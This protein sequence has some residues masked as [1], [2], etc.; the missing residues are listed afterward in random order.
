[1]YMNVNA[2]SNISHVSDNIQKKNV[3]FGGSIATKAT[4][5][6]GIEKFLSALGSVFQADVDISLPQLKKLF[7]DNNFK[8]N[9]NGHFYKKLSSIE[10]NN[11]DKRFG[12]KSEMVKD[13]F[14][15]VP[16]EIQNQFKDFLSI[17]NNS[18]LAKT[19]FEEMY[20]LFSSMNESMKSYDK[21]IKFFKE[22]PQYAQF[23]QNLAIN[24]VKTSGTFDAIS[25]YKYKGDA[26]IN[27]AL[28]GQSKSTPEINKQINAISSFI[29]TQK[30]KTPAR[31]YRGE[32]IERLSN[33]KLK[34]GKTVNLA[35]MMASARGDQNKIN[36][37]REFVLDN[38]LEA[39]EKGFM[40][41]TMDKSIALD[42]ASPKPS[43]TGR[44]PKMVWILDTKPNTKGAYLDPLNLGGKA[45][46]EKEVL[47]QRDS[48]I[49]IKDIN[50][51]DGLWYVKGEVSNT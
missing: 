10:L 4:N 35:E 30:I 23:I 31:L 51:K 33:V 28:R 16:V 9:K 20:I 44:V 50:F 18:K 14:A 47:L 43:D 37:I 29:D 3:S 45:S 19:N 39:T 5:S 25:K 21:T 46:F 13:F 22:K 8:M 38:S 6:G 2:I 32:G 41:T 26:L 42:F 36:K 12:D 1:M 40:S 34:N 48:N 17:G 49:K 11:I 15:P 24:P 27:G 7:A